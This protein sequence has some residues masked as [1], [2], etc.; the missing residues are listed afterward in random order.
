MPTDGSYE[1]FC[2]AAQTLRPICTLPPEYGIQPRAWRTL[3]GYP[4]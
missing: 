1:G 2:I 3:P 4:R